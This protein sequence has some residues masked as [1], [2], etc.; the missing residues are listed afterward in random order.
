[1]S[2]KIK[3]ALRK[4]E[5]QKKRNLAEIRS[6]I[7]KLHKMRDEIGNGEEWDIQVVDK[8]EEGEEEEGAFDFD[9]H[10]IR[11]DWNDLKDMIK[12]VEPDIEKVLTK[13]GVRASVRS[14]VALSNI[15]HLCVRIREG[16]LY[17]SQDN[18]SGY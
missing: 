15:R 3:K 6:A 10:D 4:I 11:Q 2:N 12:E 13:K 7:L 1:M 8:E 9:N 14:R 18:K 17:Q 16:I 5:I